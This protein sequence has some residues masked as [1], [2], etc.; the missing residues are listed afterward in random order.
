[1]DIVGKSKALICPGSVSIWANFTSK[2]AMWCNF[3]KISSAISN[4]K[5]L[6][7]FFLR[8][9]KYFNNIWK[10][11]DYDSHEDEKR[12]IDTRKTRVRR[13]IPLKKVRSNCDICH[14]YL[15]APALCGG[16]GRSLTDRAGV[17]ARGPNWNKEQENESRCCVLQLLTTVLFIHWLIF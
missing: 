5:I 4:S 11:L 8:F 2:S 7:E 15:R 1:M 6:N 12:K 13:E 9:R 10:P 17:W 16:S 3:S 14:S